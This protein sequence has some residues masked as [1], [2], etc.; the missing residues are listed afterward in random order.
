MHFGQSYKPLK[1]KEEEQ[2]SSTGHQILQMVLVL[3]FSIFLH[4]QLVV[5]QKMVEM[6]NVVLQ[7]V[8]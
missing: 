3:H 4:T 5:D 8:I 2:L 7:M 1:K 6:V